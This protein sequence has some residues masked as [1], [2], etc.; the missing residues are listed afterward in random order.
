MHFLIFELQVEISFES[1]RD[2]KYGKNLKGQ[3]VP[4]F[5]FREA[6]A[7]FRFCFYTEVLKK[8]A[9]FYLLK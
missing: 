6:V 3:F 4:Q 5:I 8:S 1:S 9:T 2:C 7:N